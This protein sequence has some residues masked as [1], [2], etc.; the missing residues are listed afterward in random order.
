MRCHS[1]RNAS[2]FFLTHAYRVFS[3]DVTPNSKTRLSPCWCTKTLLT[4]LEMASDVNKIVRS[5]NVSTDTTPKISEKVNV[6][7][8]EYASTLGEHV[9]QR[10]I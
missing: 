7:L 9:K 5:E 2:H 10:Y 4:C 6:L 1:P 8:S 3:R